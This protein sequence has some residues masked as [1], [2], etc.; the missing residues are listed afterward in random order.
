MGDADRREQST[1]KYIGNSSSNELFAE[2]LDDVRIYGVSLEFSEV[3][4]I[5]GEG[6]GDQYPT[7]MLSETTAADSDPRIIQALVG[8]DGSTIAVSGMEPSDWNLQSGSVLGL[9]STGDGN[10]TVSLDL[11]D[12]FEVSVISVDGNATI[13]NDG[14]P[15]ESF[16]DEIYFHDLVYDEEHLVSR[17]TFDELNGSRFRDLGFGRNDGFVVGGA[18]VSSGKFENAM[19]LDGSGD[20]MT[21]PRFAGIHREGNFTIS[22]WV[23]PTDLGHNNNVHDAAIFGTDI[24]G[25]GTVS[26]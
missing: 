10:Y 14:K 24:K 16:R 19:S 9:N 21:V 11:N 1:I 3:S 23:Y 4:D 7:F 17:W 26:R 15:S 12:S 6:F 18:S 20:Y 5:Y 13:D 25:E 22:A 8:K 2:Y